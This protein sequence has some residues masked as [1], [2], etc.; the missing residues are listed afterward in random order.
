[1]ITVS[2]L[3]KSWAM[4]SV[5]C[6]IASIFWAWRSS[7][8]KARCSARAWRNAEVRS[9][10]AGLKVVRIPRQVG[11]KRAL[12]VPHQ[13]TGVVHLLDVGERS[14]VDRLL[15]RVE[16]AVTGVHHQPRAWAVGLEPLEQLRAVQIG[17]AEIDDRHRELL[18]AH[19]L[20]GVGGGGATSYRKLL[21][22]H[23]GGEGPQLGGVVL[24]E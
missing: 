9:A 11:A 17:Q 14:H 18:P 4:A 13:L 12:H 1:M 24:H 2:R 15:G 3:L 10:T 23:D 6:P 20:Q 8:C 21:R 7:S 19:L 16:G 22:L 5:S